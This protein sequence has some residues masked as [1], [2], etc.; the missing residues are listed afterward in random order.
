MEFFDDDEKVTI[1]KNGEQVS[2]DVLFTFNCEELCKSYLACTD[3][4]KDDKGQENLYV[5]SFD[6]IFGVGDYEVVT[7]K[8]ELE[9]VNDVLQQ[10]KNQAGGAING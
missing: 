10:I 2:C 3:H 9:M 8:P 4:S 5:F 1:N 6:P 7:S